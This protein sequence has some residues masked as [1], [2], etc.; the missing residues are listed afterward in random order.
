M[1]TRVHHCALDDR[2]VAGWMERGKRRGDACIEMASTFT[3]GKEKGARASSGRDQR[4]RLA[5]SARWTFGL[6]TLSFHVLS[7]LSLLPLSHCHPLHPEPALRI[8]SS[9]TRVE[10]PRNTALRCTAFG[11]SRPSESSGL[12]ASLAWHDVDECLIGEEEKPSEA[13]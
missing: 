5:G 12:G 13:R 7:I 8:L 2:A 4:R 11:S 9:P 10:S 1:T 6:G 3:L